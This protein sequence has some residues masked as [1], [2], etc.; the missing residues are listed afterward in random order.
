MADRA[1]PPG[2]G[3]ELPSDARAVRGVLRSMGAEEAEPRVVAMLLDFVYSYAAGVL[4]D[5]EGYAEALGRGPGVVEAPELGYAMRARGGG[6]AFAGP[7]PQDLL[8]KIAEEVNAL[9]LPEFPLRHGLRLPPND[10]SLVAPN[11]ELAAPGAA[12]GGTAAGGTAAGGGGGGGGAR[13][14]HSGSGGGAAP[15]D[16]A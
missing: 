6:G 3:G 7:P 2:G 8:H 15:M 10:Q 16:T 12:G 5:A 4:Q 11:W 13:R 9:D 14:Q 1:P